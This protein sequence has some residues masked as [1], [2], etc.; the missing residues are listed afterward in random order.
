MKRHFKITYLTLAAIMAAALAGCG[1]AAEKTVTVKTAVAQKQALSSEIQVNGILIPASTVNVSIR[2]AG[3]YQVKAVNASVGSEVKE[4]DVLAVLDTAQLEAQLAQAQAQLDAAYTA[5]SGAK[6]GKSAAYSGYNSANDA[7][8]AAQAQAAAAQRFYDTL[9]ASGTAT[10]DQITQAGLALQQAKNAV[11]TCAA[12][13]AQMKSAKTTAANALNSAE[14]SVDVAQAGVDLIKL[15]ISFATVT[16]PVNG[17]VVSRN[18]NPGET[19]TSAVPLFTIADT[20][21]FKLK[22]TVPQ[23]AL[24]SISEGQSVGVNVDIY[25]GNAYSGTITLISPMAVSTGGYFPVEISVPNAA[26]LKSGL[27]ASA[28][29]KVTAARNI[30]VPLGAVKPENGQYFVFVFAGGTAVKREVKTGLSNT[31]SVEILSG[32]SEGEKVITSNVGI[33]ADNM[34]VTEQG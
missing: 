23:T 27:S 13:V 5:V 33:L 8:K 6:S 7:L 31:N 4:G 21:S 12:A 10:A 18:I 16:S 30:V 3:A 28:S 22:G 32:L 25:P 1:T 11:A 2:L 9:V 24:P 29:I 26:G 17:V 34:T 20:A 15:Q 14:A 19:A